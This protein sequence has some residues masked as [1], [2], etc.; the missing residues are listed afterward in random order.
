MSPS[1]SSGLA[2]VPRRDVRARRSASMPV[3]W[4]MRNS[5]LESRRV[6][7][8]AARLRKALTKVSC[9]RSSASAWSPVRRTSRLRIGRW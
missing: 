8:K 4:A 3:L 2:D 1:G 9:A 6:V 5:Q 7:S